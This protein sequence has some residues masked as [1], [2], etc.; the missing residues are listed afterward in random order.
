MLF[1]M[2]ACL[3]VLFAGAMPDRSFA[4]SLVI[5]GNS[6]SFKAGQLVADAAVIKIEKG[7]LLH[8]MDLQTGKTSTLNG[9]YEGTIPNYTRE[10]SYLSRVSGS[11]REVAPPLILGA[12]RAGA[13]H[14]RP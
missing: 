14:A 6:N 2:S 4:D 8:L 13:P 10:C 7:E 5:G 12:P 1:V 11:C 3:A 9:P